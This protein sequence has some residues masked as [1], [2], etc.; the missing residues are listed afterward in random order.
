MQDNQDNNAANAPVSSM[1]AAVGLVL[2]LS[3]GANI[4]MAGMLAGRHGNV[5]PEQ[6]RGAQLARVLSSFA[7]LSPESRGKAADIVKKNWPDIERQMKAVRATR[8]EVKDILARP[9]Y[10]RADLDRK[11]AE[12]RKEVGDLQATG[13]G[14]A[15]DIAGAIK[16]EERI[17]LARTL[18]VKR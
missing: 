4:F 7:D 16:P 13:Q 11:F 9:D 17:K 18:G 1:K 12:L 5:L 3:L 8:S 14:M 2:F 6:R 10:T 15:A